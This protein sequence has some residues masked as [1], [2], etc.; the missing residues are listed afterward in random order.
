NALVQTVQFFAI[1]R[2]L[3]PLDRRCRRV[4]DQVWL[5]L[6]VLL[7]EQ[8]HVDDEIAHHRQARQRTQ[9]EL[10]AA[11][12]CLGQR[13][14]T[15]EAVFAVDI[16][17]IGTADAFAAGAT[18][19]HRRI[20]GLQQFQHVENHQILAAGVDLHVDHF[21]LLIGFR[22]VTIQ[23]DLQHDFSPLTRSIGTHFRFERFDG[24]G[25]E[26]DRPFA[27]AFFARKVQGVAQ[28]G[29]VVAIREISAG[30]RAAAFR[31]LFRRNRGG[32]SNCEQVVQFQRCDT[33]GIEGLALVFEVDVLDATAQIGEFP[34]A[35]LHEF[36]GAEYT[37]VVLHDGLHLLAQL[38][39]FFAAL[40]V[41]E[42][43]ETRQRL[44][45]IGLAGVAVLDA[46]AQSLLDE[47]TRSATEYNEVEQRVAAETVGA[48]HRYAGDFAAGIQARNDDV[49]AVGIDGQ[50]LAVNVG[51]NTAHHVMAGR[52]NRYRLDDRIGVREGFRQLADT[53]QARVQHFL[54][55]VL[56]L[57]V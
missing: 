9:D 19:G 4:V 30:L 49:V 28:P 6:F 26:V 54:A 43:I 18:E 36:A 25:L 33:R 12:Q 41:V 11:L 57:E 3:Q 5:D 14:N 24:F 21:R 13:G 17:A 31:A 2:R 37:E 23:T 50:R 45:D 27:D 10:V 47:Q 32:F 7:V 42:A 40:A 56:K 39:G 20:I 16:D 51:R 52:Y 55:E 15:G 53:G 38:R 35:L 44:L 34:D 46:V 22:V 48:V 8:A 1:G 29:G